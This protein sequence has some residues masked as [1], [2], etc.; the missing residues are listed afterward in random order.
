MRNI[1]IVNYSFNYDDPYMESSSEQ[2][3]G[4]FDSRE[5]VDSR[6]LEAI[7]FIKNS[8]S[9]NNIEFEVEMIDTD[10]YLVKE[11]LTGSGDYTGYYH[12]ITVEE[13]EVNKKIFMKKN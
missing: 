11:V 5:K 12:E 10:L 7:E 6:I 13:F 9:T 3:L 4:C 2:C 8:Y 1:Y